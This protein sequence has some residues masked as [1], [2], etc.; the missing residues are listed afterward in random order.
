MVNP[1]CHCAKVSN[2]RWFTCGGSLREHLSDD[3]LVVGVDGD[4]RVVGLHP[5]R[6]REHDPAGRIG[7]VALRAIGRRTIAVMARRRR[8]L[9]LIRTTGAPPTPTAARAVAPQH[10]AP[11]DESPFAAD[12]SLCL[13]HLPRSTRRA[14][15]HRAPQE[16][17]RARPP[18]PSRPQGLHQILVPPS[19]PSG[20]SAQKHGVGAGA[21]LGLQQ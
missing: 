7:E 8:R 10:R 12:Q 5:A 17:V 2:S 6:A 13:A 15:P 18:R 9:R 20:L 14:P 3:D 4:L 11:D 19:Q 21:A 16:L 1:G